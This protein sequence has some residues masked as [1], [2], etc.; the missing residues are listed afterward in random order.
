MESPRTEGPGGTTP[1]DE[2]KMVTPGEP[3]EE[4][5]EVQLEDYIEE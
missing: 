3:D 5:P 4:A 1:A 2:E